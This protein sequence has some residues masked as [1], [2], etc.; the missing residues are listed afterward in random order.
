[1]STVAPVWDGN[2]SWLVFGGGGLMAAFPLAYAVALP[3]L[4]I[5]FSL[6]LVG[7]ILRGVAFEFSHRSQRRKWLWHSAFAF[8]STMAAAMQGIALGR[9]IQ[10]IPIANRS[11]AGGPP[12]WFAPFPLLTGAALVF[13][14]ALLGVTWIVMK[15][16]GALA[17]GARRWART[18]CRLT[19]AMIGVVS[20][21]TPFVNSAY[22]AR[23]FAWPTAVF[24]AVVPLLV[25]FSAYLLLYGLQTKRDHIPFLAS[26]LLFILCFAG[27]GISFYPNILPPALS[28]D[29]AAAPPM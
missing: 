11:Y 5:P 22:W 1:M 10:G 16:D 21:A 18:A 24:S 9:M 3:A 13:G 23:W 8:G 2:E 15:T 28:I 14:Y 12:D 17:D 25:L 19:L 29:A 20:L 7:L 26:V 6:M 4:Y 27:I